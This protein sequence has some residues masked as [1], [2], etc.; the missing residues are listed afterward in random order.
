[1]FWS[2]EFSFVLRNG[3][4]INLIDHGNQREI[5]WDAGHLSRMIDVPVWDFFATGNLLMR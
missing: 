4:S 1:M 5:P 3:K 2:G